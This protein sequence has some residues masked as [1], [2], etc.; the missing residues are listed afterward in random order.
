[1]TLEEAKTLKKGDKLISPGIDHIWTFNFLDED[2][3]IYL[4]DYNAV[5]PYSI[6]IFEIHI[7][8]KFNQKLEEILND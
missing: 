6:L 1:M 3:N 4:T 8:S 2:N 7:P 5:G